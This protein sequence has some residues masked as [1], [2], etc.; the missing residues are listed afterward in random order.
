M[1][2]HTEQQRESI[3]ETMKT[4][5]GVVTRQNHV[6]PGQAASID[7]TQH[8]AIEMRGVLIGV[9]YCVLHYLFCFL[10]SSFVS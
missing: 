7:Q 10:L 2:R 3:S 1:H 9:K 5:H 4:N 8:A 6:A